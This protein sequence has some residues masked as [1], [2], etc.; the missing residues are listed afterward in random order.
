MKEEKLHRDQVRFDISPELITLLTNTNNFFHSLQ[1]KLPIFGKIFRIHPRS[2]EIDLEI[3]SRQ[4]HVG[5]V[6]YVKDAEE[7]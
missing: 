2:K 1:L 7:L 6:A 4:V 5:C 3:G